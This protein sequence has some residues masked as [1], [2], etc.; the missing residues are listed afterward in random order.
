VGLLLRLYR[1]DFHSLWADEGL[2]YFVA[3]ADSLPEVFGRLGR[4]IHPPL[5]FLINHLFLQFNDSDFLLRLPSMLFGVGSIPLY[6]MVARRLTSPTT[7][8][9]TTLVLAISPFHIWHSQDARMYAQLLFFSL[10][11][12]LCLLRALEQEKWQWWGGYVLAV[13]AGM[14][15]QI[16]M[17]LGVLAQGL[18]VLLAHRRHLRAYCTSG[19][20]IGLLTLPLIF[21]WMSF[22]MRRVNAAK[23]QTVAEVG[24]RLG[25]SWM[26]VPYTFFAYSI[27]YSLGPGVAD[28]HE[29]RGMAFLSEFLPSIAAVGLL[30]GTLLVIGVWAVYKQCSRKVLLLCLL[31]L[32]VPL[33]G[34]CVLSLLTRFTFNAR[35][36]IVALP[37]F[38]LLLGAALALLWQR[39]PP[40]G[41][42]ATLAL[43]GLCTLSLRQYFFVPDYAKE[44]VRAAV[45]LWRQ[46]ASHAPLLSVSPAGG[47]R[48]TVNRYLAA[49]E[50]A[51]HTP[52]GGNRQ[53]VERLNIFFSTSAATSA[54]IVLVRDWHRVRERAIRQA[55]P[56]RHEQTVPGVKVLYITRA[57]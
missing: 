29:Q 47:I 19:V 8:V 33:A 46:T 21:P 52:L 20:V 50:H 37:Y 27:G 48:D 22:F 28:L 16:L 25:F 31:G 6:Y 4:T 24:D 11:S 36:T 30:F 38:S 55:F 42:I 17:A 13:T 40:V 57:P 44:D 39:Q 35:Y 49:S 18:W 41:A 43:V 51:Q 54:T 12:T 10:L 34:L 3:S 1:L 53:V 5:S 23:V 2:Q 7:A 9:L 15:S 26:A 14:Y 32:A 45:T 56:I